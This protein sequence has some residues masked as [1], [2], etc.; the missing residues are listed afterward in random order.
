MGLRLL[1]A[2]ASFF[3]LLL[4]VFF[5][6]GIESSNSWDDGSDPSNPISA[7]FLGKLVLVPICIVLALLLFKFAGPLFGGT[8]F[9]ANSSRYQE[10]ARSK[11]TNKRYRMGGSLP[12]SYGLAILGIVVVITGMSSGDSRNV[13]TGVVIG[14]I[15]LWMRGRL[16]SEHAAARHLGIRTLGDDVADGVE[17]VGT[18]VVG[19]VS[20]AVDAAIKGGRLL[21]E[22]IRVALDEA[23][24]SMPVDDRTT[25]K[26]K[27]SSQTTEKFDVDQWLTT[28]VSLLRSNYTGH[29]QIIR[30]EQTKNVYSSVPRP[31]SSGRQKIIDA[32]SASGSDKQQAVVLLNE[33]VTLLDRGSV[34]PD[35]EEWFMDGPEIGR[36]HACMW[37]AIARTLAHQQASPAFLVDATLA[38]SWFGVATLIFLE[39]GEFNMAGRAIQEWSES[40]RMLGDTETA[41]LLTLGAVCVFSSAGIEDRARAA[42]ART[43]E[44]TPC[45]ADSSFLLGRPPTHNEAAVLTSVL[46]GRNTHQFYARTK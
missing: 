24:S 35:P 19:T 38:D 28:F 44:R 7:G 16:Q 30:S 13:M 29:L 18:V 15:G 3:L 9:A 37:G 34:T 43:G 21:G 14:A 45:P 4:L 40:R 20:V 22:K 6:I 41:D 33:A 46:G 8:R 1:R 2:I 11:T 5:L 39:T 17:F 32:Y 31:V 23:P 10:Q 26:L 36:G 42:G 25:N 12:L 27:A